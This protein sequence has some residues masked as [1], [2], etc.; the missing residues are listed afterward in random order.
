MDKKIEKIQEQ[1]SQLRDYVAA[2]MSFSRSHA[3][4]SVYCEEI[5]IRIRDAR[6]QVASLTLGANKVGAKEVI[7]QLV[8]L[9]Y[10][11]D[12][13]DEAISA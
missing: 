4:S 6:H 11:L 10:A 1:C 3:D 12:L 2:I 13:I 8:K 9:I 7:N 5:K